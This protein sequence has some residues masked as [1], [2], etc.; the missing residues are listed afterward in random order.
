MWSSEFL[1]A[2]QTQN[3]LP[4]YYEEVVLDLSDLRGAEINGRDSM[5]RQDLFGTGLY[6]DPGRFSAVRWQSHRSCL[7]WKNRS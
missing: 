2:Q 1:L 5:L 4:R 3:L 7:G 6:A